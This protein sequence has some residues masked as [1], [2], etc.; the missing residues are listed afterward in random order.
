MKEVGAT[1]TMDASYQSRRRIDMT[2]VGS[3]AVAMVVMVVDTQQRI[4]LQETQPTSNKL[5]KRMSAM[6]TV[7]I[8]SVA[9]M[10]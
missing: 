9:G 3:V 8:K 2:I 7:V 6:D 4:K 1:F 5:R 10:C